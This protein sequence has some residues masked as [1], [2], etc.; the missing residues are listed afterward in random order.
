[1]PA[2]SLAS[3]PTP[4]TTSR[5]ESPGANDAESDAVPKRPSLATL[6]RLTAHRSVNVSTTAARARHRKRVLSRTT[7]SV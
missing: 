4:V 6:H 5:T 1:M 7:A 3:T 2:P